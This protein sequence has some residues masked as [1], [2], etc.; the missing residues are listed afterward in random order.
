MAFGLT[1]EGSLPLPLRNM[2]RSRS[3][4]AALAAILYVAAAA[5][6][7]APDARAVWAALGVGPLLLL[8]GWRATEPPA[9]GVDRILPPA[10]SAAKVVVAGAVL[11]LV[12]LSAPP[13]PPFLAAQRLGSAMAAVGSLVSLAHVGSLG[14][15]AAIRTQVRYHAAIFCALLWAAAVGAAGYAAVTPDPPAPFDGLGLAYLGVAASLGTTGVTLI[16]AFRLYAE[17]RFELGVAERTAA[18]LWLS[19]ITVTLGVLAALMGVGEPEDVVPLATLV[20]S[21]AVTAS[22]VSERPTLIAKVLRVAA[23]VTLLCAPVVSVAVVVAFKAPTHA[24]A[25]MFAVT[26]VAALLGL[27]AP[28]LA[29][30]LAP[31]RGLWMQV[32]DDALRAAKDPDPHQA[33]AAVLTVIRDGLG[34]DAGEAALYRLASQDRVTVDRAGYLHTE[35]LEAPTGLIDVAAMQPERVVSTEALRYVQVHRPELRDVV[36]W[37]DL[38]QTGMTALVFDEDVCVGLLTWP[39]AGRSA[40]LSYEE[41][42]SARLL[43]DH[44]GAVTGAAAQ[45]ARSRTRE[46]EAEN[47]MRDAERRVEQL[48]AVIERQARRQRAL[49]EMLARPARIASYSPAAQTALTSAERLGETGE[50]VAIVGPPGVDPLP[51]AAVVHLASPRRDGTLLVVDAVLPGD[52]PIERWMTPTSSPFDAARDGTLVI[53]DPHALPLETQRYIGT[54]LPADTGLIVV[55]PAFEDSLESLDP[56][57]VEHLGA[58]TL[59]LPTL[60]ERAEDLRALGL[61]KLSRMGARIRGRPYGLSLRAQAL[62][63]EHAWPGNEDELEAVLLRAALATGDDDVVQEDTLARVIGDALLD[64]SG[65]HPKRTTG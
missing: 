19:L 50:G 49:S 44:L 1:N 5:L 11:L 12:A 42:R 59:T 38:Q 3:W 53:V 47:A 46:L 51:W 54:Q 27:V 18:A 26:I 58:R 6:R 17:R 35:L 43:A 29:R 55:L 28:K 45:L 7:V 37:L 65:P 33:V 62:L 15:I 60:A 34:S 16:A 41:T 56:H 39:A 25:I 24:G 57:F 23:S 13:H 36:A 9:R 30:R 32:L 8:L 20:G 21:I 61:F 2:W 4:W 64:E 48:G 10:R 40:P 14:G 63:N 31:E 52:Q 22:A